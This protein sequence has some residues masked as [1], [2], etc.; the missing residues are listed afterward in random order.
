MSEQCQASVPYATNQSGRV[1]ANGEKR[2]L[3]GCRCMKPG[4][5]VDRSGDS[6][7]QIHA[8]NP[9]VV[10]NYGPMHKKAALAK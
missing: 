10:A 2:Y 1:M 5:Y 7:C 9:N 4:V 8:R 3:H 6:W